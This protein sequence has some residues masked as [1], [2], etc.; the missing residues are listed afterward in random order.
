MGLLDGQVAILTGAGR[1]IGAAAA[2]VM[3]E[4]GARLVINDLEAEP[5]ES[6][7]DS[8][9]SSGGEAIVVAG[10]VTDPEM[11]DTLVAEALDHFGDLHL[12]V[13][14]AGF[15]WDGMIHKMNDEQWSTILD[16]HVGAPFRLIR[17]AAPHLRASARTEQEAGNP[18]T[19]RA[20]VNVSSTSGL[21]GNIGQAN[22]AAAKM[23]VVGLTK[24]VAKEW[25]PFGIRCNAVAYGF[26]DTRLT[27]PREEGETIQM[28]G[29]EITLGVP[30]KVREKLDEGIAQRIPLG[31]PGT[32]DEAAAGI[33]MLASPLAGYITGHV[34]EVTGG[35][36]I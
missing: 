9:R 12:L 29:E 28:A 19:N 21:H 3:A 15:T 1:G 20:I 22:Y 31:R 24:T 13:N 34:L 17:A 23:A 14:N 6:V 7:A 5:A 36:G 26:I 25:G 2:R 33:L 4:Q 27:R 30:L 35:M 32:V 16:V 18:Q 11:P 10:S 8:I